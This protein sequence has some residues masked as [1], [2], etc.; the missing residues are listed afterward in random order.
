MQI[1]MDAGDGMLGG[2][3]VLPSSFKIAVDVH[4]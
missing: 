4:W 2:V 3:V 1:V